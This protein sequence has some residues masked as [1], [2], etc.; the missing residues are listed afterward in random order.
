MSETWE[1]PS[2]KLHLCSDVLAIIVATDVVSVQKN[3]HLSA[4][5]KS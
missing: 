5:K 3:D 4:D 1:L 2:H